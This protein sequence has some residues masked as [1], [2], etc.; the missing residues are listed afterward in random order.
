MS[1]FPYITPGDPPPRSARTWNAVMDAARVNQAT[2][3]AQ[4]FP[5][6]VLDFDTSIV[7]VKNNSGADVNRFGILGID[8]PIITKT[9]NEQEFKRQVAVKGIAP[10][11]GTHEGLFVV[12]LEPIK[13]GKI[14]RSVIDGVI[15]CQ[16]DLK[17]T[18]DGFAEILNGDS[19]KLV[20]VSGGSARIL[21]SGE[22]G[23][24]VK[25]CVV[26]LCDPSRLATVEIITLANDYLGV[27]HLDS[28]GTV[29]G[30]EFH[31]A[32]PE[33]LRHDRLLYDFTKGA[34]GTLTTTNTN[35]VDAS[36]GTA[37]YTWEVG[38][39]PYRVGDHITIERV[40]Y[41]GVTVGS[42]LKWLVSD[43]GG[44]GWGVPM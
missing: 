39:Q 11:A 6:Q 17:S 8:G 10:A 9:D 34:S 13:S 30:D 36:D 21:Y 23:T 33:T 32:K 15:Q 16:V 38:P 4:G 24:G 42:D 1:Q 40:A 18:S 5:P 41:S 35:E 7:L 2:P 3:M 19:A 28:T 12:T 14:G 25:D 27:K 31:A 22:S 29:S 43:D 37:T 44:R 26:R 20:S